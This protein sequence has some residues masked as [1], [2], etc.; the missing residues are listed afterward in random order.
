MTAGSEA[1]TRQVAM[2]MD[3]DVGVDGTGVLR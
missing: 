1:W 2:D 3:M